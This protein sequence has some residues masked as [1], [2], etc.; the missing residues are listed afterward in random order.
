MSVWKSDEKLLSFCILNFSFKNDF[1]SSSK[2]L[3][4]ASYFQLS[5]RCFIWWW[6]TASHVWYITS[7]TLTVKGLKEGINKT[8][9][10]KVGKDG[11][12][13]RSKL[14]FHSGF[15]KIVSLTV[16]Q[17]SYFC[18]LQRSIWCLRRLLVCSRK[19]LIRHCFYMCILYCCEGRNLDNSLG[20]YVTFLKVRIL[21]CIVLLDRKLGFCRWPVISSFTLCYIT[22]KEV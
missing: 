15:R 2:I 9:N 20:Y 11:Q 7:S 8:A 5:S 4:C 1:R 14:D 6:N 13:W 21:Y 19:I 10:T 17:S 16:H 12:I 18:C 22:H 3:R